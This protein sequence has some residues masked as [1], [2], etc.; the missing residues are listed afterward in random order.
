MNKL[1]YTT[2]SFDLFLIAQ[3]LITQDVHMASGASQHYFFK[4]GQRDPKF[5]NI[6]GDFAQGFDL[7]LRN[8]S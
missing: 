1:L 6:V 8:R 7:I 5:D 3:R 2:K 4:G